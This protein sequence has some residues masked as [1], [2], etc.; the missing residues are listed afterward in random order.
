MS[1]KIKWRPRGDGANVNVGSPTAFVDLMERL[2]GRF[3]VELGPNNASELRIV[4]RATE[5]DEL[6]DGLNALADAIVADGSIYIYA[7]TDG[8]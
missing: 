2:Y 8:S 1:A 4:A 5:D 7:D 6:R 3:P